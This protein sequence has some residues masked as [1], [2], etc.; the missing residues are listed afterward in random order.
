MKMNIINNKKINNI[1]IWVL[2]VIINYNLKNY[3]IMIK[4]LLM[5]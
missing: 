4:K 5:K 3:L 2:K 1:K